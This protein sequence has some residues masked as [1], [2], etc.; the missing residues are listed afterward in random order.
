MFAISRSANLTL[1]IRDRKVVYHPGT[2]QVDRVEPAVSVY[3]QHS[4]TVPDYAREAVSKMVDWGRGIGR[5]EDPFE[6]CGIVDTDDLAVREM[7]D[8]D[9]KAEVEEILRKGSGS[10]Y[11]IAEPD[12]APKPWP[13]Y[14]SLHAEDDY[15]A[16]FAISKKVAED[17]YDAK[18][19]LKYEGQNQ[20]RALVIDALELLVKES[21]ADVLGVISA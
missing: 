7:W 2:T 11:V 19:V 20:K 13:N 6:R 14:D 12:K 18:A 1:P 4:G 10:L 8:E 15:E 5:D 16:A 3:F 17:G 9:T 21:E